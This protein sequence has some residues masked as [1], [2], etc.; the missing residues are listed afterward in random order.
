MHGQDQHEHPGIAGLDVLDETDAVRVFQ[1]HIHD[2]QVRPAG[3]N[4]REG[5]IAVFRLAAHG[6]IGFARKGLS[7]CL[8]DQ[9]MVVHEQD[10]LGILLAL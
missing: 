7:Q 8:P 9:W 6:Q 1:P 2:G 10:P 3:F 4:R 5:P